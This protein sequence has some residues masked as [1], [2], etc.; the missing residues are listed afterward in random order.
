MDH[1]ERN[2]E[3]VSMKRVLGI[4]L[5]MTLFSLLT[6]AQEN[7]AR[8][9]INSFQNKQ[10]ELIVTQSDL[11]GAPLWS[12]EQENPPLSARAAIAHAREVATKVPNSQDWK[13]SRILLERSGS[14]VGQWI[15]IVQFTT[16]YKDTILLGPGNLFDVPVL[17]SGKTP[18]L[19]L[20]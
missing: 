8:R 7:V 15:Y 2:D 16:Y 9:C 17:L 20:K 3:E 13:V 12:D 5:I 4:T 1:H 18:N 6:R 19:K 11:D 10:Y 14:R